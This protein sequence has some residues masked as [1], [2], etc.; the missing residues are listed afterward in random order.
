MTHGMISANIPTYI[1]SAL[2]R[3]K[4]ESYGTPQRKVDWEC[5]L[6]VVSVQSVNKYHILDIK[7][8]PWILK[9][10]FSSSQ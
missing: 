2:K 3:V 8:F 6:K 10:D 1:C 5:E 9:V 7:L 4:Q